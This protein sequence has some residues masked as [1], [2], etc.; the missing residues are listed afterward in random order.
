MRA[1][2]M[3]IARCVRYFSALVKRNPLR[4][5]RRRRRVIRLLFI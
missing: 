4:Q 1:T 3:S 2:R 5:R